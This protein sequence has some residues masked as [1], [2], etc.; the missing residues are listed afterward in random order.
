MKNFTAQGLARRDFLKLSGLFS[1]GMALSGPAWSMFNKEVSILAAKE[2]SFLSLTPFIL[3][4]K[5]SGLAL[6]NAELSSDFHLILDQDIFHM[7]PGNSFYMGMNLPFDTEE[8]VAGLEPLMRKKAEGALVFENAQR[9]AILTGALT[10]RAIDRELKKAKENLN[11]GISAQETQVYQDA[12][13]LRDY[14]F[15]GKESSD[16]AS[17]SSLF[18]EMVP[19]TLIRFHTIMPDERMGMDWVLAMQ[20]WRKFT[21][22]YYNELASA[23]L[24]PDEQ[25]YDTII[26]QSNFYDP[27]EPVM[28][29]SSTFN[30]LSAAYGDDSAVLVDLKDGLTNDIIQS[31]LAEGKSVV[32]R[33]VLAGYLA[34]LSIDDFW[35]GKSSGD[36]LVE[37]LLN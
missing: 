11:N 9:L 26:R 12:A 15:K 37:R 35:K 6:G 19:R 22:N 10:H 21:D 32:A 14:Y 3:M 20:D 36:Q 23:I 25:K 16:T 27:S 4:R 29:D 31:K 17:L 18:K 34:L 13:L 28:V 5:A 24:K 7:A 1:A 30:R 8:V 33:A 2:I